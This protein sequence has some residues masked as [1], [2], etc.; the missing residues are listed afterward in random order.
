MK[1]IIESNTSLVHIDIDMVSCIFKFKDKYFAL[2]YE[3]TDKFLL[4]NVQRN[5]YSGFYDTGCFIEPEE[6]ACAKK[7]LELSDKYPERFAFDGEW[8]SVSCFTENNLKKWRVRPIESNQATAKIGMVSFGLHFALNIIITVVA[9]M[10]YSTTNQQFF[11][12]IFPS[13]DQD[14]LVFLSYAFPIIFSIILFFIVK[15]CKNILD[16]CINAIVPLGILLSINYMISYWW[17][18]LLIPFVLF[19]S[20]HVVK[21][22]LKDN[23]M[24]SFTY[25]S[26]YAIM[27]EIIV[28]LCLGMYAGILPQPMSPEPV[29]MP[30]YEEIVKTYTL[31]ESEINVYSW[32]TYDIDKKLEVLQ[33]VVN[34]EC[35]VILGIEPVEIVIKDLSE[36]YAWGNY[37]HSNKTISID[38]EHI[39]ESPLSKVL[40]TVIHESRHAYQFVWVEFYRSIK[41]GIDPKYAN[42]AVFQDAQEFLYNH[43]NYVTS[44][45]N[46]LEYREQAVERDSREW[47]D[48]RMNAYYYSFIYNGEESE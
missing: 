1:Q 46:S 18:I 24:V 6:L 20:Y 10:L 36:S 31:D 33:K 11:S 19:L 43:T 34:Y 44:S 14:A 30:D 26:K 37:N 35:A 28:L 40:S 17:M 22:F 4:V 2:I 48:A 27:C 25:I 15:D 21:F 38:I 9:A 3:D 5:I 42:L 39:T 41:D 32:K 47:A 29:D 8:Y 13:M 45:E 23:K 16:L 7:L 12:M